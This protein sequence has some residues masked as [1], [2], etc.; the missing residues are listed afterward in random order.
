MTIPVTVGRGVRVDF[1][2]ATQATRY[3]EGRIQRRFDGY[4]A[5]WTLTDA[6]AVRRLLSHLRELE[7]QARAKAAA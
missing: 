3:L 2:T 5:G 4:K 7:E 1:P 6:H